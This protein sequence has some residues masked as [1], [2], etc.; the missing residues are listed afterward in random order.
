MPRV[1][2]QAGNTQ[3]ALLTV[4][5]LVKPPADQHQGKTLGK[6]QLPLE[7]VHSKA[8]HHVLWAFH[9]L[10]HTVHKQEADLFFSLTF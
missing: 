10:H 7:D 4:S 6:G 5:V 1:P 3:W 2:G 8:G 9:C